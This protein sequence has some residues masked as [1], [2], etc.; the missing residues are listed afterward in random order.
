ME[1]L[2]GDSAPDQAALVNADVLVCTPEKWDGVSRSWKKR[3]FVQVCVC[4]RA[5]VSIE[6]VIVMCAR[7]S[8]A[9]ALDGCP[10]CS[11]ARRT[12]SFYSP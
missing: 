9:A 4:V 8:L 12:V 1:E 11:C 2:T 7:L 10:S 3:D 5:C 6:P